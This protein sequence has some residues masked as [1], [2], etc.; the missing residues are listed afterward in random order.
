MR[1]LVKNEPIQWHIPTTAHDRCD[2]GAALG[3]LAQNRRACMGACMDGGRVITLNVPTTKWLAR[4]GFSS[5]EI[6]V[7]GRRGNKD[8]NQF[9]EGHWE[10]VTSG[11]GNC[12]QVLVVTPGFLRVAA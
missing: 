11:S 8:I 1:I 9:R 10:A 7:M 3:F 5:E 2:C 6:K 12:V 4:L